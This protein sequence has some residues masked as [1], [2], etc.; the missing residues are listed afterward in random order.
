MRLTKKATNKFVGKN[1][2]QFLNEGHDDVDFC[3][4]CDSILTIRK[5][6]IIL[7]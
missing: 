3:G 7:R 1:A 5:N 6:Q 4:S 2:E